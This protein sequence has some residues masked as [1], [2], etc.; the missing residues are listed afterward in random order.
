VNTSS[1]I[2]E[3]DAFLAAF[4][5]TGL[6][7]VLQPDMNG[8]LRGKRTERQDFEKIYKAGM[9]FSGSMTIMDIKGQDFEIVDYACR[10]GDPD[11]IC[12]YLGQRYRDV[13]AVCR[14]EE[15]ERF[16]AEVSNRDFEWYLRAV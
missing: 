3:L 5:D 8:V 16:H 1:N 11:V 2:D 14:R 4:P 7:E 15:C 13:F 10:D 12:H 6:L 9:N